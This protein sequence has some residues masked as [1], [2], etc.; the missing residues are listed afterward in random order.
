MTKKEAQEKINKLELQ[1]KKLKKFVV[2]RCKHKNK[3]VSDDHDGW[4][5]LG[6]INYTVTCDDCG[7]VVSGLGSDD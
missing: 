7:K 4:S 5:N 2:S 1:I 3:T 6:K